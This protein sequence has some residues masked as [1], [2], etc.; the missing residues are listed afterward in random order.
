MAL[1]WGD[2]EVSGGS[3]IGIDMA[4]SA[5]LCGFQFPALAPAFHRHQLQV[6]K[7]RRAFPTYKSKIRGVVCAESQSELWKRE[8]ERWVR[9][10]QRWLR[11]EARWLREEARL[12][13]QVHALQSQISSLTRQ[14]QLLQHFPP[15]SPHFNASGVDLQDQISSSSDLQAQISS[16]SDLQDQISSLSDLQAKISSLS[17]LQDQ[18]SSP[19]ST[20]TTTSLSYNSSNININKNKKRNTLKLGSRGEAVKE[21]QEALQRLGFYSGEDDMDYSS[22]DGGTQRAVK[23][24]QAT[25]G[26]VE[27]GTMTAELLAK[28]LGDGMLDTELE[29]ELTNGVSLPL[30]G[31]MAQEKING[32]VQKPIAKIEQAIVSKTEGVEISEKRVYL[33]GENRWEEPQRLKSKQN[34]GGTKVQ[35]S[36]RCISCRGEG[37]ML[38]TE[39]EGTGE[40]NV[41]EQFLEWIE[42]AKCPYCEGSGYTLCDVCE[43]KDGKV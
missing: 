39:C 22:F 28:L 4:S 35:T 42:E 11:E 1:R 14:L 43:G 23:S 34:G 12:R 25:L 24:W 5:A 17:D 8:E 40:P 32:S 31:K 33:L 9:E 13:A 2:R 37:K 36:A 30:P 7:R 15:T 26:I 21:M 10:E 19:S 20:I 6:R 27:D 41:E 16:R 38:C 29:E 18:I 3:L